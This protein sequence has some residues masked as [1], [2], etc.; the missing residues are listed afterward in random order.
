LPHTAE[1]LTIDRKYGLTVVNSKQFCD[2]I[3][4]CTVNFEDELDAMCAD[5]F[6]CAASGRISISESRVCDGVIDCDDESDEASDTCPDRFFCSALGGT[7]VM[8]CKSI[9]YKL[10]RLRALTQKNFYILLIQLKYFSK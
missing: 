1:N 2:G 6:W 4:H 5:R 8:L 3:P 7:K 9:L 10:K